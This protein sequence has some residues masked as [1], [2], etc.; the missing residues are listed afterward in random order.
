MTYIILNYITIMLY[1]EE[2]ICNFTT[3]LD[4]VFHL[5]CLIIVREHSQII[6]QIKQLL[7]LLINNVEDSKTKF[8]FQLLGSLKNVNVLRLLSYLI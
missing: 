4:Y 8:S 2:E 3:I 1:F 7:N 5:I 6:F